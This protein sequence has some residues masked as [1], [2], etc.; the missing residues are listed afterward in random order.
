M[1]DK[2]K[3]VWKENDFIGQDGRR[4][5]RMRV[6][7]MRY[8]GFEYPLCKATNYDRKTYWYLSWFREEYE[9][10]DT[11]G[12]D[13]GWKFDYL[14]EVKE[15]VKHAVLLNLWKVLKTAKEDG[16]GRPY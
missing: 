7:W 10:V 12:G 1:P 3:I 4:R 2:V 9:E 5:F 6:A 13:L 14:R 15:N 8:E 16:C 11:I